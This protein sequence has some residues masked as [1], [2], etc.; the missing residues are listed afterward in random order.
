[1]TEAPDT[2]VRLDRKLSRAIVTGKGIKLTGEELELLARIGM[3]EQL[4]TAKAVALREQAQCRQSRAASISAGRTGSTS[5]AAPMASPPATGGTSGGTMP[6][7]ADS[8]ARAR[9]LQ[10]FA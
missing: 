4:S 7:P 5:F 1:M 8:N 2:L 6:P 9:A 10:T 3:I